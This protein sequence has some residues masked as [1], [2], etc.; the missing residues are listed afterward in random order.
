MTHK[1][2][3]T[4]LILANYLPW[5]VKTILFLRPYWYQGFECQCLNQRDNSKL[6]WHSFRG[7]QWRRKREFLWLLVSHHFDDK[8]SWSVFCWPW[9]WRTAQRGH[10]E[11]WPY[12]LKLQHLIEKSQH[13]A[14][15]FF[16]RIQLEFFLPS[17]FKIAIPLSKSHFSGYIAFWN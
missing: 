15:W 7:S 8:E 3:D 6:R 16:H 1:T 5:S 10:L 13:L 14:I 12:L 2:E 4:A 17:P 9:G 11:E